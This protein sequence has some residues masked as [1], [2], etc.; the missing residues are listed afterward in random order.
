MMWSTDIV[1]FYTNNENIKAASINAVSSSYTQT[2]SRARVDAHMMNLWT[3]VSSQFTVYSQYNSPE[4][5]SGRSCLL[6]WV[7]DLSLTA[8][9]IHLA[10]DLK[11][12][13]LLFQLWAGLQTGASI[14]ANN[15]RKVYD[16]SFVKYSNCV[17]NTQINLSGGKKNQLFNPM[18][19]I[20][21]SIKTSD[22]LC[23]LHQVYNIRTDLRA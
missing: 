12:L 9:Q 22:K 5:S 14:P 20:L 11:A 16:C 1:P 13:Q 3:K 17:V 18:P 8:H 2:C 6:T 7:G 15:G 23:T 4:I 10:P 21:F 19:V